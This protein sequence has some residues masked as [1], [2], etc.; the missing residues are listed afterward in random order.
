MEKLTKSQ[1]AKKVGVSAAYI[2]Q[3]VKAKKIETV[4]EYGT[5]VVLLNS[6]NLN[7]FKK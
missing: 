2:S 5:E 4:E 3:L 1:F 7:L 6:N